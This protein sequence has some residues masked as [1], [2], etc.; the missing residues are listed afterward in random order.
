MT[1][2]QQI[3]LKR[4]E[5]E[6]QEAQKKQSESLQNQIGKS[7]PNAGYG[8]VEVEPKTFKLAMETNGVILE[9]IVLRELPRHELQIVGHLIDHFISTI[10]IGDR[11]RDIESLDFQINFK[12]PD[13]KTSS[14]E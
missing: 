4:L 1:K 3:E 9:S 2:R 8:C 11:L 12:Q 5:I 10:V 7:N 14:P 6:K 13:P